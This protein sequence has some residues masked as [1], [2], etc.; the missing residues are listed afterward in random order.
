MPSAV[1]S[2]RSHSVSLAIVIVPGFIGGGAAVAERARRRVA[3]SRRTKREGGRGGEDGNLGG[4]GC[5]AFC[6]RLL[7]EV[8][9]GGFDVDGVEGLAGGHEQAVAAGAAEADVA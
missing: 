5:A 9:A 3:S 4:S 6:G 1:N 2:M 7:A 8:G